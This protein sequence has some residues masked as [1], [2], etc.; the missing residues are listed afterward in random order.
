MIPTLSADELAALQLDR[1]QW[2]LRH[3]YENVPFY[4]K[5]FDAAGVHPDDC[6]SLAGCFLFSACA[7]RATG[8]VALKGVP[9]DGLTL[10]FTGERLSGIA[11]GFQESRL[12]VLCL[13]TR[14]HNPF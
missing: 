11:A 7:Y 12:H 3:A 8:A 5:K 14:S 13:I 1:L 2:T 9:I 10:Y 6:E 4:T